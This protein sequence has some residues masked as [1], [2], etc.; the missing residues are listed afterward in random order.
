MS[1]KFSYDDF[2]LR[3]AMQGI[4]DDEVAALPSETELIDSIEVS[5]EFRE[6]MSVLTRM[7]RRRQTVIKTMKAVAAVFVGAILIFTVKQMTEN[8]IL[9]GGGDG[10]DGAA[11]VGAEAPADG[12]VPAADEAPEDVKTEGAS[13]TEAADDE[14]EEATEEAAEGAPAGDAGTPY[15]SGI[16]SNYFTVKATYMDY[17]KNNPTG[18]SKYTLFDIDGDNIDEMIMYGGY[19]NYMLFN[20]YAKEVRFLDMSKYG[21]FRVYPETHAVWASYGHKN[22]WSESWKQINSRGAKTIAEKEWKLDPKTQTFTNYTY[23]VNGK[24]VSK[25]KYKTTVKRLKKGKCLKPDDFTWYTPP[26]AD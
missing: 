19:I 4:M 26:E 13:W 20:Y 2:M 6:K 12:Y 1:K 14:T 16:T 25:K 24:K 17:I 9:F 23:K 7:S 21:T 8:G 15:S 5:D 22:S 3:R 18:S 11:P 10:A